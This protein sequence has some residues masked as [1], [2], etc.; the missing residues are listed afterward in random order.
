LRTSRKKLGLSALAVGLLSTVSIAIS[1][2]ATGSSVRSSNVSAASEDAT[3]EELW[4]DAPVTFIA[5]L[6][7]HYEVAGGYVQAELDYAS[8]TVIIGWQE[9]HTVPAEVGERADELGFNLI[10]RPVPGSRAQTEE[11]ATKVLRV[12]REKY[13]ELATPSVALPSLEN[14]GFEIRGDLQGGKSTVD[15]LSEISGS[16]DFAFV[17]APIR[18]TES[19]EKQEPLARQHPVEGARSA[20]ASFILPL[21]T[22]TLDTSPYNAGGFITRYA[23]GFRYICSNAFGLRING[24]TRTTTAEHCSRQDYASYG[25]GAAYGTSYVPSSS[26]AGRVLSASAS[27]LVFHGDRLT[28][29]KRT[30][31]GWVSPIKGQLLCTGGGNSGTHC[32]LRVRDDGVVYPPVEGASHDWTGWKISSDDSSVVGAAEGDSGGPVLRRINGNFSEVLASGMIQSGLGERIC[33]ALNYKYTDPPHR[34]VHTVTI[35]RFSTLG[36][37]AGGT[38]VTG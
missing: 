21:A 6:E 13:P 12:L 26:A 18:F 23:D 20:P 15:F 1:P 37:G 31:I 28:S 33:P 16:G 25:G 19:N 5:W 9:G 30:V 29:T 27:P 24:Y 7:E 10:V 14:D 3:E 36:S 4:Q 2:N 34:C 35:S 32:S 17:K 22:R 8:R 38:L 11:I